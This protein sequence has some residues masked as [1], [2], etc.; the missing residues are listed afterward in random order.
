MTDE[1]RAVNEVYGSREELPFDVTVVDELTTGELRQV[2][3]KDMDF[4]H[5]IGHID[6]G[7]FECLDGMFEVGELEKTGV[8]AF[9]LNACDSYWQGKRLVE[10]GS[11]AG[12]ATLTPVPN[13]EA[14]KIGRKVAQLLNLG[15]PL[16][17]ALDI[18]NMGQG[19]CN[20][21]AIGDSSFNIV[22]PNVGVAS[23]VKIDQISDSYNI[24]YQ[25]H[26]AN[27]IGSITTIFADETDKY[28]LTSG[29]TGEFELTKNKTREFLSVEKIPIIRGSKIYWDETMFI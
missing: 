15:F 14:E 22:Q 2:L 9:F 28:F 17:A 16:Y 5:Y 1:S 20:Y 12:V 8:D 18:A 3:R 23:S 25:T 26:P 21:I 11:I 24:T 27:E 13:E 6:E 7:G 29:K 10:T 4:F 19:Y